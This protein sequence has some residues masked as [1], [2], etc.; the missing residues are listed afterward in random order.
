MDISTPVGWGI[1][2]T[3]NMAES[4]ASALGTIED[5]SLVA[6]ASRSEARLQPSA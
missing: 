1:V 3:G 6:I 5:S 2:G 4:F